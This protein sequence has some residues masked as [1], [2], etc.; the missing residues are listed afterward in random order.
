MGF[1]GLGRRLWG[2]VAPLVESC[3]A[4]C[5]ELRCRLWAGLSSACVA[6]RQSYFTF[7]FLPARM[8]LPLILLRRFSLAT[9][10]PLRLA[11]SDSVSPC[12]MVTDL[13]RL[14]LLRLRPLRPYF[15]LCDDVRLPDDICAVGSVTSTSVRLFWKLSTVQE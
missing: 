2:A 11:M 10:V 14:R 12:R 13:E 4:A 8:L 1:E 5:G 6:L 9:V 7:N 15:V 3:G